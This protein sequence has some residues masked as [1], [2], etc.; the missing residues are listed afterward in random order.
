LASFSISGVYLLSDRIG[1][2]E[3]SPFLKINRDVT[4]PTWLMSS[5]VG[6]VYAEAL[7]QFQELR[8][9]KD[10]EYFL[11]SLAKN[12]QPKGLLC[13]SAPVLLVRENGVTPLSFQNKFSLNTLFHFVKQHYRTRWVFLLFLNLFI[14]EKKFPVIS[15]LKSFFYRKFA[16]VDKLSKS[17]FN[18]DKTKKIE[19]QIDVVIP[20]IGRKLYLHDVLK[21]LSEQ[22]LLPQNVI[23]VEQNPDPTSQTEL[24]YLQNDSWPFR[25][26]HK[27]IHK[28]GACNARNIALNEV[29]SSWVFLA[30]DDIR[31]PNNFIDGCFYFIEKYNSNVFT[32]SCLKENES[33]QITDVLQWGTFG[34]GCSIISKKIAEKVK[35]DIGYEHGFGEDAD[36]GMQIRNIGVDILYNPFI[37]LVHSKAP[38]GGFRNKVL[39]P[40][41]DENISPK[42][43]PTVM[44]F[45][46]KHNT[47]EQILG[48]KTVL[49]FKFYSRQ[50]IK[51]P[52]RYMKMMK[53]R[54]KKSVYWAKK[55]DAL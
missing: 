43:S 32:V 18:S 13:Y 53:K 14:Y 38:I 27:F 29:K 37:K 52:L 34:S 50:A 16:I 8:D 10:F 5:D 28:T 51:N 25:I 39:L 23:I 47:R 31:I 48:Y 42:P 30:D 20:S 54:W 3:D 12:G 17:D 33:E 40:W 7:L 1:Y 19:K 45:K 2:V 46:I 4:Y 55:L 24:D 35:F 36:F 11:N 21:D 26:I 15:L 44:L 49:F 41:E 22:T 9:L 6:G